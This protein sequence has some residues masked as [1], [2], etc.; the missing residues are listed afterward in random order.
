MVIVGDAR[1]RHGTARPCAAALA[2]TVAVAAALAVTYVVE[3]AAATW[4]PFGTAGPLAAVRY[5]LSYLWQ[6]YLPP[7]PFMDTAHA[8]YRAFHS[9]P[10]WRVW[11]ETGVGFFGWLTMPMPSWAYNLAFW[12]L[13]AA[14]RP[15]GLGLH[16]RALSRS[17]R[18]VPALLA[19]ALGYVLLLHLA[20]ILLL[21]QGG[22]DLLLQ[23]RYLIPVVPLFAAALYQ[24]FSRIGRVGSLAAGALLLV[25]AVLSVEAMNDVLVFFG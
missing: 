3:A 14:T 20:E 9:L 24:P 18:A 16:P 11:V 12:S 21:L 4:S 22:S 17:E 23:G 8:A 5:G 19:A 25:A 2:A 6:F 7:L 15:R 13:V 1:L 10:S